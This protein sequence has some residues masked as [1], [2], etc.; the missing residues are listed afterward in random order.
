MA[1]KLIVGIADMKMAK[2]DGMLVTYALGSCIG[3][4]L[5][6]PLPKLGALV[7]IMLPLNLETGRTHPLKYADTGIRDTLRQMVL[8]GANTSRITAKIAGGAKMFD[9]SGSSSLGNI[10]Q[11][12]IESVRIVLKKEGVRLLKEDVGGSVARTLLFDVSNG[13]GC[14]RSYG[15]PEIII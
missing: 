13:M 7:H 5:Y 1:D 11:R 10:G 15:K 12:N 3:I 8:R 4:C 9:V 6:D 2:G 14:V